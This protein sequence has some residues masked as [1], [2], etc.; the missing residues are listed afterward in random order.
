[1]SLIANKVFSKKGHSYI[2]ELIQKAVKDGSNTAV[3]TGNWEIDSPVR[4]PS[5]FSLILDGCHLRLAD[6][7]YSNIFTNEHHDTEMGKTVDGTDRNISI[8]GK[9]SP[10]LDGGIYNGLSEKTQRKN[11][12][13]PIYK[14]C[15]IFFTNVDGFKIENILCHNNRWW[16]LNFIHCSNGH[17][18]DISFKSSDIW[19]DENSVEH[20]GLSLPKYMEILVKTADG[21]DLRQGCHD[22]VVENITGFI[23]DDTVAMTG[24]PGSMEKEFSV[25][26]LTK[27]IYNITVKDISSASLCNN[28][29]ILNQGGNKMYNILI[30]GVRDMSAASPYMERGGSTVRIG[31]KKAYGP[32][33]ASP[34]NTYNISVKNIHSRAVSTI[35]I[36]EEIGDLSFENISAFDGSVLMDDKRAE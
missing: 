15:F 30:D 31:D 14:N 2:T 35:V 11:G 10:V 5:N 22:I 9:N 6:G 7:C 32:I 13:P 33:P 17:I 34:A 26:G 24:L 1:M 16:A 29:R 18:S 27:D 12:L 25:E 36:C 19:V 3:V 20:H 8:I 28:I 23:E 21:I 4:I